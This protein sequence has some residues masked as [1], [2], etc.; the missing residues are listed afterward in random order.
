MNLLRRILNAVGAVPDADGAPRS[1]RRPGRVFLGLGV[2]SFMRF[3]D[4]DPERVAGLGL[5]PLSNVTD[6][7]ELLGISERRLVWLCYP[8][9]GRTRKQDHYIHFAVAKRSGGTRTISAPKTDMRTVQRAIL[10]SILMKIPIHP[11]ATA[12]YTGASVV[13]HA[14]LHTNCAV[15]VKLDLTDFF[16]TI[17][18]R[19]VRGMFAS[20][21]YST[22]ISTMLALLTTTAPRSRDALQYACLPQGAP[23]SPAISNIISRRLDARLSGLAAKHGFVYSRYADDMTFSHASSDADIGR[24]VSSVQVIVREEGFVLNDGKTRVMRAHHRQIV[25][26]L[27]VNDGVRIPRE[28]LRRFRAILHNTERDGFDSASRDLGQ[29]VRE[30]ARGYFAFIR[31]VEPDKAAKLVERHP[32]LVP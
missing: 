31:S 2:Q 28:N 22:G 23:T 6:V 27:V 1:R 7:A 19:R 4:G 5:P 21:G 11:A 14:M 25:T 16:P 26:G 12:F 32:W 18:W 15:V 17:G 10:R 8:Q 24:L 3:N 20:L 29:D 13:D 30:Y 9:H